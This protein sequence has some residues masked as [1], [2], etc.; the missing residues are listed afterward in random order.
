MRIFVIFALIFYV[1]GG[2]SPNEI[3]RGHFLPDLNIKPSEEKDL[4]GISEK[5]I[6]YQ[7]EEN[8]NKISAQTITMLSKEEPNSNSTPYESRKSY[9]DLSLL[10]TLLKATREESATLQ[11]KK[12]SRKNQSL[13]TWCSSIDD[14]IPNS[15]SKIKCSEALESSSFGDGKVDEI[16]T[17]K[18][19]RFRKVSDF[20]PS[21]YEIS[22]SHK[23]TPV[24]SLE[25]KNNLAK[26][27]SLQTTKRITLERNCKKE[28][29]SGLHQSKHLDKIL[30][31][32]KSERFKEILKD[33]TTQSSSS[34][35]SDKKIDPKLKR[36]KRRPRKKGL[37]SK[38]I[39]F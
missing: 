2:L 26:E 32:P 24:S 18:N 34:A 35:I 28:K 27:Q 1:K 5:P 9:E 39:T 37:S 31:K 22:M 12:L 19:K 13:T 25:T 33:V 14:S 30:K 7:V 3:L 6:V 10:T 36:S 11:H 23:Y 21:E 15:S 20:Y 4:L 38:K 17:K 8:P 29:L 16:R